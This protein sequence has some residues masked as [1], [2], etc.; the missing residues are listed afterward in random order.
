MDTTI[1]VI[2]LSLKNDGRLSSEDQ[3][4][5]TSIPITKYVHPQVKKF[6]PKQFYKR[7][8]EKVEKTRKFQYDGVNAV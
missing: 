7:G 8:Q 4:L 1:Y 2:K 3:A 5:L 6:W